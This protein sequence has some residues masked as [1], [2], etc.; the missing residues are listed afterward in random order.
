[1]SFRNLACRHLGDHFIEHVGKR[2]IG[3]RAHRLKERSQ[4]QEV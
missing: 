3:P 4:V 1:M 2:L